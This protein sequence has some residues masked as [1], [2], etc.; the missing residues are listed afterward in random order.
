MYN[1]ED[2][3]DKQSLLNELEDLDFFKS[4]VISHEF[5]Q[6]LHYQLTNN[7]PS[8]MQNVNINEME[9]LITQFNLHNGVNKNN[10]RELIHF[11]KKYNKDVN[12]SK[13]QY[14][15]NIQDMN[16]IS[17]AIDIFNNLTENENNLE[18]ESQQKD[19]NNYINLTQSTKDN[20]NTLEDL[21]AKR[22]MEHEQLINE[23][24]KNQIQSN[25]NTTSEKESLLNLNDEIMEK[26]NELEIQL[27]NEI[28][29]NI[30]NQFENETKMIIEN[31]NDNNRLQRIE[32]LE[33]I[34]N[35]TLLQFK[36]NE[37]TK[38]KTIVESESLPT[39]QK[40]FVIS[41]SSEDRNKEVDLNC[42]HFKIRLNENRNLQ[43]IVE[44][45]LENMIVPKFSDV[46]GEVDN[47][48][49]LLL[50]IN[51]LGSNYSGSNSYLNKA[52]AKLF[53]NSDLGKYKSLNNC[54]ISKTFNPPINLSSLTI[55]IRKPNGDL[56]DFGQNIIDFENCLSEK[57]YN[58][59]SLQN[60]VIYEEKNKN[61]KMIKPEIN[62]DLKI[63]YLTKEIVSHYTV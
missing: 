22:K 30:E 20:P 17:D 3:I 32:K 44:V 53:F 54:T 21:L 1:M 57:K 33:S 43:N 55:T 37:N 26:R 9:F 34:K 60:I 52:F 10:I 38:S 42:N 45:K 15:D 51:E 47:Y 25:E 63:T 48:P 35:N 40:D 59:P 4:N 41:I 2:E 62:I 23:Y 18:N 11:L 13:E 14:M 28:N 7:F 29:N 6:N 24:N 50:E 27:K 19:I 61:K 58:N 5:V 16:E 12:E 31:E 39:K 36:Q 46:E 8:L 49:F 56:Y